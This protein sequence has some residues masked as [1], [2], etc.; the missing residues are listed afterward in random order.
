M[1]DI[2]K[3]HREE[4][5]AEVCKR[6]AAL[7]L[8]YDEGRCNVQTGIEDVPV[9]YLPLRI[10]IHGKNSWRGMEDEKN[11]SRRLVL[12]VGAWGEKQK[13]HDKKNGGIDYD[14]VAE[15][16][17]NQIN[18]KVGST[19]AHHI[20]NASQA[21]YQ[22]M[23]DDLTGKHNTD[24]YTVKASPSGLSME[25]TFLAKDPAAIERALLFA[26]EWGAKTRR[27][28]RTFE[29]L[30]KTVEETVR[31]SYS[32]PCLRANGWTPD[33][34]QYPRDG[35][36]PDNMEGWRLVSERQT[37]N[38]PYR[39]TTAVMQALARMNQQAEQMQR[40]EEKTATT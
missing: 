20:R 36:D 22:K 37:I 13:F 7:G 5:L 24:S 10:A 40:E 21:D 1:G 19:R 31:N 29:E 6:T 27:P 30:R 34:V 28:S 35:Y 14:A 12:E 17:R 16:V 39:T 8:P 38:V 26:L 32:H 4:I 18:Q 9:V 2:T 25:V 11:S 3:E 33:L 15:Y 23:A